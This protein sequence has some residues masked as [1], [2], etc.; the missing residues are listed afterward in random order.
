M[1]FVTARPS[2]GGN[3]IIA[4][5][6]TVQGATFDEMVR[7]PRHLRANSILNARYGDALGIDTFYH[8]VAPGLRR[9]HCQPR[10]YKSR[11]RKL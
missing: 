1:I 5:K 6:G 7:H 10:P 11:R 4:Y 2:S 3:R 8:S 9:A